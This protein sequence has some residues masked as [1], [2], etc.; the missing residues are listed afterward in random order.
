MAGYTRTDTT[1]NIATG[2]VINASDLDNEYD[3]IQAAY[4]ATTGHTHG[5]AAGEGA[6]ITRVGPV[7]DVVVS[8]SAVT[9]KTDNVMDLGSSSLEFKD[10]YIDGTANIDSLVA[11]TADINGG[12][13]DGA[14]IG[15]AS[16]AAGTF[17]T[18]TATTGNITTVNA[19]TVNTTNLDLTNLEVTNI[20][21]K[22]GTASATIADST[23]VMTVASA[24]LTTADINGGTIDGAVIGGASAAAGNFTT[25][26][27]TGVATFSAG[28]VSAPAI[29]TTG[30][31]NTGIFFPAAD[32]IA[33]TEGGVESMRIDSSGNCG[34]GTSS[35]VEKLTVS[36]AISLNTDLVLKEGTTARGYIFGT[37]T[38]LTYRATSGLPH[39][40]QNVGTELMRIT[41][42]GNVGIGTSS[43][44]GKLD[45]T[46][47][48]STT[49]DTLR[50]YNSSGTYSQAS[51]NF[52][53]TAQGSVGSVA[54]A[55]IYALFT[56]AG[57]G[58]QSLR[59]Q[60]GDSGGTYQDRMTI[61]SSGNVGIG[62][63]NPATKLDITGTQVLNRGV[64]QVLDDT[65]QA[66]GTGSGITLGGRFNATTSLTPGVQ[67][68]AAKTNGT[69][70]DYGFDMAFLTYT[71]AA[72]NMAERMR[73][74][75]TGN[76]GIGTSSPSS[77]GRLVVSTSAAS[78]STITDL[79][80][81]ANRSY[82]T[83]NNGLAIVASASNGTLGTH[84]FGAITFN[85]APITNGSSSFVNMYAGGSSS[86]FGDASRFLRAYNASGTGIDNVAF[87]TGSAE[88]MR[89]DSSGNV[90]I[91][92]SSPAAK[93]NVI[94]HSSNIGAIFDKGAT[95]QYGINY[96]NSAQTYTQYVDINNNGTNSW[97]LY[98][99]TNAQLVDFYVPT[100]YRAFY[101]AGTERMRIDSSG[102][103]LVG[104]TA[105]PSSSNGGFKLS[106]AVNGTFISNATI[107]T[108]NWSHFTFINGNGTVGTI[109]TNGT[110]TAYNTSSDYRLKNITGSLTGYKER[111]MSL[112]PKQG[113][114]KADGSEFKGFVAHEFAQQYPNAVSGEKDAL[115]E[116]GK[117]KYQGMQA[118]GSETIAD[119]VALVQE[120]Q[121]M[122]E[123]LTTRLNALEG[124]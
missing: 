44:A 99:T 17:T 31:T 58:N 63:I 122:I 4:N 117:P 73:I 23:G 76:V 25:L 91:G 70:G 116:E 111:I 93:L 16:A 67:I 36:G 106:K 101:T 88:R 103:L 56:G 24:V 68:K 107:A 66:A 41:S 109:T 8:G 6:P 34:I 2:N 54:T 81:Q 27:A 96:K 121:A 47:N 13:V 55:R 82:S 98:D 124:K 102:N 1:N 78:N 12:T 19:T 52:H 118:G 53:T 77:F 92:T 7:Q 119:L 40:F 69:A 113:T 64:L 45:V 46:D 3:A 9:P 65:T 71:N 59:F 38:G 80:L 33:F 97:S 79:A 22:D 37:S 28:T 61:D 51:I 39:I 26:G 14:V 49:G 42:A 89:I 74:D 50:L 84:D 35:P 32:T 123:Q 110:A 21:A 11:D 112:Q 62:I 72:A 85:E 120:Q 83:S 15:G 18:A 115:D 87:W 43:P 86:A 108:D 48:T 60:T 114:W 10:L 105:D 30:D 57:F 20:K 5:G 75:T 29:T 104:T 95:T 90:G 100:S 94:G